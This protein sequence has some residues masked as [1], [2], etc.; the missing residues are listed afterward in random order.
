MGLTLLLQGRKVIDRSSHKLR[1]LRKT[2]ILEKM[3]VKKRIFFRKLT[4]YEADNS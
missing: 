4:Q 2:W 3:R 1:I